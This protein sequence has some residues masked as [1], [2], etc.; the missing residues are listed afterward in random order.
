MEASCW[1]PMT[2]APKCVLAGDHLQLPPTIISQKAA[3][4]GLS[5]TLMERLLASHD[6]H[7]EMVRMLTVQYRMNIDIMEWSSKKLYDNKLVAHESVTGH[8]LAD[9]CPD[10]D[11]QAL[12]LI[13]TA[14][15]DMQ[16]LE[17]EDEESKGNESEA[18]IAAIYVEN[19]IKK[20][21]DAKDIGV[22]TPYNLQVDLIRAR[23]K[24]KYP[25]LEIKSVDGIQGRERRPL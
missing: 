21:L 4:A 1:I 6:A 3:K 14:G 11:L 25:A 20:G 18:D 2:L 19:L 17:V 8:L 9:I 16:E 10:L 22:I 13:D 15:C 23:L 7:G 24:S 5:L 12:V